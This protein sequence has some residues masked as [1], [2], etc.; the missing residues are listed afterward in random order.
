MSNTPAEI[1]KR[2]QLTVL[3]KTA[4]GFFLDSLGE[5]GNILEHHSLEAG[6]EYAVATDVVALSERAPQARDV[7]VGRLGHPVPV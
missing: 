5:L 3:K 6:G 2:A 7:V 1:G 4:P